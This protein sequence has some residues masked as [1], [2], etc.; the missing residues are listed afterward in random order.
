MTSEYLTTE[1]SVREYVNKN[2][3]ADITKITSTTLLFKEGLFD[4][5]AFVLIIDFLEETFCIRISDEDLIEEN[6]ESIEA[7]TKFVFRKKE[8][9]VVQ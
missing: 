4:S 5:M 6:F 9:N 1:Q 8:V 3:H 2:V 7:I